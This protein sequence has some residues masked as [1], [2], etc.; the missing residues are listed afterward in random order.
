MT[1][2]EQVLGHL[3]LMCM[4]I[5]RIGKEEGARAARLHIRGLV[6]ALE[7]MDQTLEATLNGPKVQ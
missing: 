2:E 7:M 6:S 5:Y 1:N 4:A 3:E